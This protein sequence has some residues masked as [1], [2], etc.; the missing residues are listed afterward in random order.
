[1]EWEDP[2]YEINRGLLYEED[3]R[4]ELEPGNEEA[5]SVFLT[6][7]SNAVNPDNEDFGE[8]A[9]SQLSWRNL[10]Y[11]LGLLFDET[12]RPLKEEMYFWCVKQMSS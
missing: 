8:I 9:F 2:A 12:P 3:T 7:W 4:R 6:G 11:R 5:L 1:M 10:G